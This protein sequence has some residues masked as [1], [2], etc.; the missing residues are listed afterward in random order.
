M[1]AFLKDLLHALEGVSAELI[2][3]MGEMPNYKGTRFIKRVIAVKGK[4]HVTIHQGG[5]LGERHTLVVTVAMTGAFLP[6][7]AIHAGD[8]NFILKQEV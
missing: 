5:K 8:D 6:L 1:E 2:M 3:N 4:K 7:V